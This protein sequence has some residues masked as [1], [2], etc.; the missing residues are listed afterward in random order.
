ML[1]LAITF[2]TNLTIITGTSS[3]SVLVGPTTLIADAKNKVGRIFR[4]VFLD[5]CHIIIY[6]W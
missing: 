1:S 5:F 2:I 6:L 3:A 4:F